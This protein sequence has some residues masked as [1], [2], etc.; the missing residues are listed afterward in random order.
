MVPI[1]ATTPTLTTKLTLN[2]P[3]SKFLQRPML[4]TNCKKRKPKI[5]PFTNGLQVSGM[6]LAMKSSATTILMY[7]VP[8]TNSDSKDCKQKIV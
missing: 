3:I 1:I 7:T 5:L 4:S 2:K 8:T 6:S